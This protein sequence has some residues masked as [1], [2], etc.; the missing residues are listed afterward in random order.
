MQITGIHHIEL[1]VKDLVISKAFY[2]Q[3]PA[4]KIVAEYPSFIM[5]SINNKIYL[6]LTDHKGKLNNDK[7]S[8]FNIGLD[9]FAFEID[10]LE[11]LKELKEFL[12]E[13]DIQHS[14]IEKLS[15]DTYILTFRDPDN[16]Q[17]E[18]SFREK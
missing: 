8:E 11:G 7:F 9:H 13:K 18:F 4:F 15:N 1:T 6:G 10:S 12:V 2:S 16:I 14:D 17:L 3:F 5:F